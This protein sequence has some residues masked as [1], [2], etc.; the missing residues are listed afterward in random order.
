MVKIGDN[1][2]EYSKDFKLFLTSKI[3]NP[4]YSPETYAKVNI[5]NF[6]LTEEALQDQLLEIAM[7]ID[8]TACND[9][10]IR[11][12]QEEYQNSKQL[13]QIENKILV[14]LQNSDNIL[15]NEEACNVLQ[16]SK[17]L[18]HE[19]HEKQQQAKSTLQKILDKKVC[20]QPIADHSATLFSV[21]Q[22]IQSLDSMY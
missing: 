18:T 3:S 19:I 17:K 4:N 12:I 11:L 22:S 7:E 2:V 20:Y 9:E 21:L 13:M 5:I 10:N 15:D 8:E 6:M 14:I 16:N 1:A